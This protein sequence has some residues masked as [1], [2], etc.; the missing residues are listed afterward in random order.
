MAEVVIMRSAAAVG[1]IRIS[2]TIYRHAEPTSVS[3]YSIGY[4]QRANET[5][6]AQEKKFSREMSV[7]TNLGSVVLTAERRASHLDDLISD[8]NVFVS[9]TKRVVIL[10]CDDES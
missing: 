5:K 8:A 7:R 3:Q 9:T 6:K 2:V 1:P 10:H 4:I